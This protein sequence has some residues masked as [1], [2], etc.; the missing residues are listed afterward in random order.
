L[1]L[2]WT[3]ID[4]I[5]KGALVMG[6]GFGLSWLASSLLRRLPGVSRAV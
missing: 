1:L 5:A 3:P 2:L 4:P 6:L